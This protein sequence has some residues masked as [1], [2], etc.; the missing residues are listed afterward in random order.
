M[1][2]LWEINHLTLTN[3]SFGVNAS[4]EVLVNLILGKMECFGINYNISQR[5]LEPKEGKLP[6]CD[7]DMVEKEIEEIEKKAQFVGYDWIGE[8]N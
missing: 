1:P 4:A 8:L 2:S 7:I 5:S 3:N 6:N